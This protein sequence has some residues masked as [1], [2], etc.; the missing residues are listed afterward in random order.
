MRIDA[1]QCDWC[2]RREINPADG[3]RELVHA[4]LSSGAQ[5]VEHVC[6]SCWADV[7]GLKGRNSVGAWGATD[8]DGATGALT[9]VHDRLMQ[10]VRRVYEDHE[11]VPGEEPNT[12][13]DPEPPEGWENT[14]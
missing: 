14:D 4:R 6:P 13:W 7:V 12:Q 8:T 5:V 1:Y 11:V 9:A 2:S 3:W 10:G